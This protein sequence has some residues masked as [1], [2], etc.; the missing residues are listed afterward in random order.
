Y[1]V[2]LVSSYSDR[3]RLRSPLVP[4]ATLFRSDW[5]P[6]GTDASERAKREDRPI[7]LVVGV[8][9][10]ELSAAMNRQTFSNPD[11][12]AFLNET[13][14]CVLV[15]RDEFPAVA[16]QGQAYVRA[17]KQLSGWPLNL[18]LTPELLP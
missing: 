17:M 14:V 4:Y 8:S 3:F 1:V 9:N 13:Y 10:S 11:V 15:D 18:W 12:A 2:R 5:M 7:F 6:W 16:A